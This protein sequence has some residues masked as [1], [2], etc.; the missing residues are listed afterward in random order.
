MRIVGIIILMSVLLLTSCQTQKKNTPTVT[1]EVAQ[2]VA[3]IQKASELSH[4]K[5]PPKLAAIQP[6]TYDGSNLRD[7]FELPTM[8]RNTKEY[9]NAIL[10]NVSLD[11]LKLVGIVVQNEM[12]WAIF[13]A[14][15]GQLYKITVGMRAG[16][17]QALLTKIEPDK[18]TFTIDANADL[19]EKPQ[20]VVF[21]T[22]EKT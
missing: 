5:M 20:D 11:S 3:S 16:F 8:V 21:S 22:Q 14:N 15:D 7:P 10:K 9:P 18:V 12:R 4:S 19:G 6:V 17:Q 13:K 2:Y 1:Q